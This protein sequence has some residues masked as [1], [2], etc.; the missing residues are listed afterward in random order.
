MD[1]VQ[2]DGTQRQRRV[3]KQL[4][5]MCRDYNRRDGCVRLNCQE[6]HLCFHFLINRCTSRGCTKAHALETPRN[7]ILLERLGWSGSGDMRQALDSLRRRARGQAVSVCLTYNLSCCTVPGCARLHV[8]YRHVLDSCPLED[9]ALSHDV[10]EGQHNAVLLSDA[11]QSDTPVSELMRRLRDQ[12]LRRPPRPTLCR[13]VYSRPGG[14]QRHC[15]RLHCCEAFTL[16]R[17]RYGDECHRSHNLQDPHNRLVLRFFGWTESQVLGALAAADGGG[18][19]PLSADTEPRATRDDVENVRDRPVESRQDRQGE[20]GSGGGAET[21]VKKSGSVGSQG[22]RTECSLEVTLE[23]PEGYHQLSEQS[24]QQHQHEKQ[25]DVVKCLETE[26]REWQQKANEWQRKEEEWQ[27]TKKLWQE[28]E[29]K[30]I[31]KEAEEQKEQE[32]QE[33]SRQE[34][35]DRARAE[36]DLEQQEREREKEKYRDEMAEMESREKDLQEE[37]KR[38][39]GKYSNSEK[40]MTTIKHMNTELQQQIASL[41]MLL[42]NSE[43]RERQNA[44]QL[45]GQEEEK[46]K[47]LEELAKLREHARKV[48]EF[49][50]CS[51]CLGIFVHP[52]TLGCSHTF[53]KACI[54]NARR[55]TAADPFGY[56]RRRVDYGQSHHC[57]LCRRVTNTQM[58]CLALEN[59]AKS[60]ADVGGGEQPAGAAAPLHGLPI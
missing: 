29:K 15:L 53:C 57:P 54:D 11:G 59:L 22:T 32:R 47:N 6:L 50:E 37:N 36:K 25:S 3:Q 24:V 42:Q 1:T 5:P 49:V 39:L 51:I 23:Y 33:R 45:K 7:I 28:K 10:L 14:C 48:K 46:K 52:V 26:R 4:P 8:C 34:R 27:R 58:T 21:C 2:H 60:I 44:V 13:A 35:E 55:Q 30:R 18:A 56:M 20:T 38:L 19:A 16:G 9:C 43:C 17:C 41:D 40:T 31:H 12:L